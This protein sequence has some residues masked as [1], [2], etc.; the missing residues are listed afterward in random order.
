MAAGVVDHFELIQ[1]EVEQGVPAAGICPRAVDRGRQPIFELTPIDEPGERIVAGLI[2]Q[3][4][5]QAAL[6]ADVVEHQHG[7]DQIARTVADR[8]SRILDGDLLAST[9]D[10]HGVLREI[11]C[12]PFAQ[13]AHHRTLAGSEGRFVHH[14]Q[15]VTDE[16]LL[17][18]AV[19]PSGQALGHGIHIV[20]APVG[21]GR[22]D[23]VADR[24]Q[25]H[26]GA[27]FLLKN[28]RFGFFCVR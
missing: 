24:P 16:L 21:V 15:N 17:R 18:L 4:A 23:A 10:G 6:L 7:T 26:L 1:I 12:L 25:R 2:M 14:A 9:P 8:R 19:L 5:V 13:T 27:L 11:E 22:D 28:G 3:G 20:D